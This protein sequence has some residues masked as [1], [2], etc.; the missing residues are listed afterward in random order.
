MPDVSGHLREQEIRVR[1][2]ARGPRRGAAA[3]QFPVPEREDDHV[4]DPDVRPGGQQR[5]GV[6]PFVPCSRS[7][8]SRATDQALAR[9]ATPIKPN[10]NPRS[11]GE[12]RSIRRGLA[13]TSTASTTSSMTG[14]S[15]SARSG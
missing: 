7:S 14:S 5:Y 15:H 11:T 6:V 1:V 9:L 10:P 13:T 8:I 4:G 2:G 12:P 3:V